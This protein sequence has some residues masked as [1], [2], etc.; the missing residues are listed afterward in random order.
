[1]ITIRSKL[2]PFTTPLGTGVF[3]PVSPD[4][5]LKTDVEYEVIIKRPTKK[6]SLDANAYCW[7][8]C[9]LIAE[10]LT[11][12]GT[13]TSKED[14]YR[15]CIKESGQFDDIAVINRAVDTFT[16]GWQKNG[17]GWITE[18]LGAAHNLKG[19]TKI[20]CYYGS[21]QYN[22]LEMSRLI[23]CLVDEAHQL[24]LE[25]M[26]WEDVS[27]LLAEWEKHEEK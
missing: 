3:I 20:R 27:S 11:V 24:G 2:T 15:R 5:E 6:R 18:N 7:K 23:D 9:Q 22:S 25:T 17:I 8:L 26:P 21:S 1:M 16:A 4:T 10:R 14:V 13:F 12:G 19:C